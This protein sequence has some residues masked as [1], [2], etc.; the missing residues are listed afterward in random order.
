MLC[1]HTAPQPRLSL[2]KAICTQSTQGRKEQFRGQECS[3]AV[4]TRLTGKALAPPLTV[5]NEMKQNKIST[6]QQQKNPP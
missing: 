5:Q 2:Y 4:D 6:K 3:T 1:H